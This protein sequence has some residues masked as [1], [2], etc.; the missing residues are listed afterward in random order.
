MSAGVGVEHLQAIDEIEPA[1][2]I[3]ADPDARGLTD[4]ERRELT[5][6]LVGEGARLRE[7]PDGPLLVDVPGH[8]ANLAFAGGDDARAVRANEARGA[9]LE[10]AAHPHH[11]E[12]RDA[13]GD[14]DHQAAAGVGG[15]GNGVGRPDG[16]DENARDIGALG[17]DGG[18]DR[19]EDRHLAVEALAAAERRHPRDHVGPVL[20]ARARVERPGLA[21]DPLEDDPC[22]LVYENA[23]AWLAARR[24]AATIFWAPSSIDAAD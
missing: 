5:H 9:A 20:D 3:A 17:A 21:G 13:V 2:G 18:L 11:I 16:R 19:V 10:E 1:H 15:L 4:A 7:H 14:A 24:V 6:R 22:V 8:D 23:H 12:H